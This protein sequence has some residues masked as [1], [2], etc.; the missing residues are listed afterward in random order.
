M[1]IQNLSKSHELF[2]LSVLFLVTIFERVRIVSFLYLILGEHFHLS[3]SYLRPCRVTC[4][5]ISLGW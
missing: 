1:K 2:L 3:G 4:S 5:A